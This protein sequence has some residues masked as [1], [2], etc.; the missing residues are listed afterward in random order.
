MLRAL[1]LG[2]F[3]TGVP[4]MRA[5]ADSFPDHHRVLVAPAALAPLARL[6]GAVDVL[7]PAGPLEPLEGHLTGFDLGVNL[8]GRG[9]E[10][11]RVLLEA[12]PARLIAWAHPEIPVTRGF[13]VWAPDEH[14]VHRWCRLL[15]EA[16]VPAD[17][18][19]L[20]LNLEGPIPED[21]RGAT[22]NHPGAASP[23]RRWPAARFAGV[24]RS[25]LASGRRVVVTGGPS[26]VRLAESVAR[27]GGIPTEDVFAGQTDLLD[28][29]GLVAAAGRVVCGDTGVA[30]LATALGTPSVVLF[31]PASPSHWGP[32]ADRPWHRSLRGAGN[33]RTA[34]TGAARLLAIG[35]DEVLDALD[36]LPEAA[37]V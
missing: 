18:T 32:P 15:R 34:G 30:H 2:D 8:H 28:L 4:A 7:A 13:P 25:E 23:Y 3:L 36:D 6:T 9:P 22:L 16:G 1:G 26:E 11:H 33:G 10:S 17:P 19:R 14:E 31:G 21:L 29:A 12:H 20:D 24:A 27:A 35:V 5:L 37:G